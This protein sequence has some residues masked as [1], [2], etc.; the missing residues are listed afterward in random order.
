MDK[1]LSLVMNTRSVTIDVA[2]FSIIR[3]IQ[4]DAKKFC[5]T[6]YSSKVT[7]RWYNLYVVIKTVRGDYVSK[8]LI[9]AITIWAICLIGII[10]FFQ[11]KRR[12]LAEISITSVMFF[13]SEMDN[14]KMREA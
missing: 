8:R 4:S 6:N 3:R 13:V 12:I 7:K 10:V 1:N 2:G 5:K 11:G 9:I 14:L